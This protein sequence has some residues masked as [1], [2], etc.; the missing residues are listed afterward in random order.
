MGFEK[1]YKKNLEETKKKLKES[2]DFNDFIVQ[3]INNIDEINRAVNMLSKRLR[4]WYELY[5]PELS[6]SIEEHEKLVSL[7]VSG[8]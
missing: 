6:R 5:N 2:V 3:A 4:E 1:Y 7:I 8:K